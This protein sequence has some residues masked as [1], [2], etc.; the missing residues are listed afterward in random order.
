MQSS[1]LEKIFFHYIDL[2]PSLED[3]V[4]SR[5]YD[6]HE[7]R[8]AHDIRKDFRKK[9]MRPPTAGQMKQIC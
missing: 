1:H 5:F 9:Y 7:I 3:S 2:D 6:N 4:L 8:L